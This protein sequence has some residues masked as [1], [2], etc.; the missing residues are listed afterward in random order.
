MPSEVFYVRRN[1]KAV[2]TGNSR[3]RG[4]VTL[5]TRQPPEGRSRDGG[6][7]FGESCQSK[8][9]ILAS[10]HVVGNIIKLRGRP[11]ITIIGNV[12]QSI[13]RY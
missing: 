13:V 8:Y 12:F 1:G 4:P 7:R 2:W 11:G 9:K 6:L 10:L 3:A 5:L